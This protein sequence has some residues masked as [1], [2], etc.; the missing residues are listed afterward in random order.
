MNA[1]DLSHTELYKRD[2]LQGNLTTVRYLYGMSLTDLGKMLDVTRQTIL[3]L[4]SGKV[5]M[6]VA[7][8]LALQWIFSKCRDMALKRAGDT[9]S[10]EFLSFCIDCLIY[11]Q[12]TP[13]LKDYKTQE[14]NYTVTSMCKLLDIWCTGYR[15]KANIDCPD[16]KKTPEYVQKQM[17]REIERYYMTDG[18]LVPEPMRHFK[19]DE[20]I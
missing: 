14:R 8:C 9:G 11:G 15:E 16:K 3:N 5:S 20:P 12:Q 2:H 19:E 17:I 10:R 13:A 6:T 1:L 18:G 7:Q 4:E